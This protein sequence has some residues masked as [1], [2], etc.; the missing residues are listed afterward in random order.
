[1]ATGATRRGLV[2]RAPLVGRAVA[3]AIAALLALPSVARSADCPGDALRRLAAVEREL[4]RVVAGQAG[5]RRGAPPLLPGA[6]TAVQA[7][8]RLYQVTLSSQDAPSCVFTPS[9]SHF[10]QD[11]IRARGP[12]VGTLMASDRLQRCFG[13]ARAY[14]PIDPTTQ[15]AFDPALAQDDGPR[16]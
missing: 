10:A 13:P 16:P 9:C 11:A 15:R 6:R 14:Y 2:R 3:G 8:I 5:V 12:L 1:M 4:P 7:L